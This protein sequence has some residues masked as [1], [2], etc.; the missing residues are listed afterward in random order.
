MKKRYLLLFIFIIFVG[1]AIFRFIEVVKPFQ[2]LRSSYLSPQSKGQLDELN[3]LDKPVLSFCVVG[4]PESDLEN[5]RKSLL[6]NQ[7]QGCEFTVIVGDLT[8]TGTPKEFEKI[9]KT[10]DQEEIR[11]YLI[12]GNHDLWYE[13]KEKIDIWSDYFGQR[14]YAREIKNFT[15]IFLDNADEWL[16]FDQTQ[17]NWL[18]HFLFDSEDFQKG[19]LDHQYLVFAHIPFWHPESEKAMGEYSQAMKNQ[20]YDL[21]QE[22]CSHPPLA[23]FSGHL[24]KAQEY[25]YGCSNG[26]QIRMIN[27]GSVNETRNWQLPRFLKAD[28]LKDGQSEIKEIELD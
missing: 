14:Y 11:Y 2:G 25:N 12:P 4:D 21:L 19:K 20:A 27:A 23:I 16:G 10:L 17:L 24:H 7:E 13:H 9:K 5:L 15:F 18:S 26:N 3:E 22:F 6:K 1:L 8:Q 28:I